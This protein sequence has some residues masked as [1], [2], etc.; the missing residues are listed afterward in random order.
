[1]RYLVFSGEV[2]TPKGG[3][4]DIVLATNDFS[5]AVSLSNRDNWLQVLDTDTMVVVVRARTPIVGMDLMSYK[6]GPLAIVQEP[7]N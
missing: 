7:H 3:A 4:D 2:G 1:M 5:E 6:P